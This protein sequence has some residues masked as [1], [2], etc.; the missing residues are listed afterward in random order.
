MYSA[1][2][3][4]ET[5]NNHRELK[6]KKVEELNINPAWLD[7]MEEINSRNKSINQ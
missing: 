4:G 2:P 3:D 1:K 7:T 6:R 5:H